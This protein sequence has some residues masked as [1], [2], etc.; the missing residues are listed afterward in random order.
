MAESNFASTR[1]AVAGGGVGVGVGVVSGVGAGSAAGVGS[2]VGDGVAAGG[3]FTGAVDRSVGALRGAGGG[4]VS[5]PTAWRTAAI[6][7]SAVWGVATDPVRIVLKSIMR[8]YTSRV[9]S[10]SCLITAPLKLMPANNPRA[11]E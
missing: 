9:A 10:S 3:G 4:A 1:C 8:P 11:R 5:V 2:G 7:A 6:N